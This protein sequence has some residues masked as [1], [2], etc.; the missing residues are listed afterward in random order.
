MVKYSKTFN[1]IYNIKQNTYYLVSDIF[2]YLY[3]KI[4]ISFLLIINI[5]NWIS[6]RYIY[7]EIGDKL[8]ALHYNVDFGVN[9][10]GKAR[11][12][13]IIPFL[14]LIIIII[15]FILILFLNRYKDKRFFHHILFNSALI[16]NLVLLASIISIYLINFL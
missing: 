3:V 12:I 6:A 5:L 10:I 15:N 1:I 9:Y 16:S 2:S 14:G 8:I 7:T 4:Y 13:F 11:E